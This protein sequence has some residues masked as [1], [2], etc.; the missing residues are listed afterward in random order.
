MG[1]DRRLRPAHPQTEA[2]S[3][4]RCRPNVRPKIG[5][6]LADRCHRKT[7]S[8]PTPPA[9]KNRLPKRRS[10]RSRQSPTAF[11]AAV[12]PRRRKNRPD[13]PDARATGDQPCHPPGFGGG[14][15]R[16]PIQ[17]KARHLC[18]I[19]SSAGHITANAPRPRPIARRNAHGDRHYGRRHGAGAERIHPTH[20]RS[21]CLEALTDALQRR[22][23]KFLEKALPLPHN[24]NRSRSNHI[25]AICCQGTL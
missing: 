1:R 20:T 6:V 17:R 13:L 3:Q 15:F 11:T 2:D 12:A 19:S 18:G 14:P 21:E 23:A 22:S 25:A 9:G 10:E 8:S 7:S 5:F 16:P 4:P 24:R